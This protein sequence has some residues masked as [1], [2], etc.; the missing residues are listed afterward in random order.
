MKVGNN[1]PLTSI[2]SQSLLL[3]PNESRQK[4]FAAILQQQLLQNNVKNQEAGA[5]DKTE[6]SLET[7]KA[8]RTEQQLR[9]ASQDLEAVFLSKMFEV[10]RSTI[11]HSDLIPRS[12]A[13]E[14]F[15]SMLYD[16]YAKNISK[17]GNLGIADSIYRQLSG[18]ELKNQK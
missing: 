12:F 7:T 4:D 13:E 15:E 1:L 11:I 14:T 2:D 3:P 6:D 8:D 5:A 10:M 17:T 18:K 9:E 16:E